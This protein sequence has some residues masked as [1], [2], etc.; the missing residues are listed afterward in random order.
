MTDPTLV[1]L[2]NM[3][4]KERW[5]YVS[6][7]ILLPGEEARKLCRLQEADR[8]A[9][10]YETLTKFR[11]GFNTLP[12]PEVMDWLR[13]QLEEFSSFGSEEDS[14]SYIRQDRAVEEAP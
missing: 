9:G 2:A 10:R 7:G 8:K 1:E 6:S 3:S 14:R 11:A 5:A 4:P 13:A 12:F